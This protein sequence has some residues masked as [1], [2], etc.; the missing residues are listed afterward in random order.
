MGYLSKFYSL[1]FESVAK[2]FPDLKPE[3]EN[4]QWQLVGRIDVIDEFGEK[5]DQYN[6]KIVFP[7]RYPK[8]MPIMFETG[9]RIPRED[10]YHVNPDGS[11]CLSVPAMEMI[12][13]SRGISAANFIQEL[14]IPYL[15]NHTYKRK[16][17]KFAREE[18]DH[19]IGG[20]YQFYADAFKSE[21]WNL[22]MAGL[23]KI[24]LNELPQRNDLCFCGSAKKYKN[25]HRQSVE[26]LSPVSKERLAMDHEIFRV[27]LKKILEQKNTDD[28]QS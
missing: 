11:C 5:W 10:D 27:A 16:F 9:G 26:Y 8:E 1:E 12:I 13:C 28:V 2:G 6:V 7:H 23:R 17:N 20:L 21:Q 19:G 3:F 22:I 15:A 18:Y 4:N 24:V 14:A 25:C